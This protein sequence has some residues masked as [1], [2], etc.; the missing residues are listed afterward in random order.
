MPL[1]NA[2][3]AVVDD[4]KL[5]DYCLNVEHPRG[6]HKATVFRS[7]LG[8]TDRD[9]RILRTWLLQAVREAEAKVGR[10][11][12]FGERF[13]IDFEAEHGPRRA[14]IRSVWI[15]SPPHRVPRLVTCH[16]L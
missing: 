15:V 9:V 3:L 13:L 14:R 8:L 16:V 12:R 2:D 7:A 4:R 1:P 10:S 6:K 11:D 5:A